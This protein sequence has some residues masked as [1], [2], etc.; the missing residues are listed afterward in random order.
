[1]YQVM[2]GNTGKCLDVIGYARTC[3]D[4]LHRICQAIPGCA[5]IYV[6]IIID[7]VDDNVVGYT[8]I[9]YVSGK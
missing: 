5:G 3:K 6:V 4:V 1:M 8:R 7:D 2:L 9:R